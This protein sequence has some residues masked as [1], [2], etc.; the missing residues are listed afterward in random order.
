ML[1]FP[2]SQLLDR[3]P[4]AGSSSVCLKNLAKICHNLGS[5]GLT[6]IYILM[7]SHL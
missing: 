4:I 5:I 1:G 7:C 3:E 2:K 6:N